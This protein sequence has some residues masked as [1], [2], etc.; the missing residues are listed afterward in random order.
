MWRW[1]CNFVLF[2]SRDA[3]HSRGP[4]VCLYIHTDLYVYIYIYICTTYVYVSFMMDQEQCLFS[5]VVP[6]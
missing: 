5:S 1:Q 3:A 4:Y 6:A 2:W